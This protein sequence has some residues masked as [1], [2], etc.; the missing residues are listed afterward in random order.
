M[1]FLSD[2]HTRSSIVPREAIGVQTGDPIGTRQEFLRSRWQTTLAAWFRHTL[3]GQSAD[4]F[5]ELTFRSFVTGHPI[6]LRR[7]EHWPA[8]GIF[9]ICVTPSLGLICVTPSLGIRL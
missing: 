3:L 1:A 9:L 8:E 4:D 2:W 5:N 6:A 7:G